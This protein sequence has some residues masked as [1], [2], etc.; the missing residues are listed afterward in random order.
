MG[1]RRHS[2]IET[3][4]KNF[5]F[6]L[7]IVDLGTIIGFSDKLNRTSNKLSPKGGILSYASPP[8][9]K[10]HLHGEVTSKYTSLPSMAATFL[11]THLMVV[12]QLS[13]YSVFHSGDTPIQLGLP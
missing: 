3:R 6:H 9:W 13:R 2:N 7:Y 8:V 4:A 11:T 1:R 5:S 10:L 12:L